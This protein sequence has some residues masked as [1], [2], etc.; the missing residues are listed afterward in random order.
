MKDLGGAKPSAKDAG[1]AKANEPSRSLIQQQPIV[2]DDFNFTGYLGAQE[3]ATAQLRRVTEKYNEILMNRL[4][5]DPV[6]VLQYAAVEFANREAT[7]SR[8]D[9]P[10]EERSELAMEYSQKV[11]ACLQAYRNMTRDPQYDC[12]P[13]IQAFRRQIRLNGGMA[14]L[15][16]AYQSDLKAAYMSILRNVY[17]VLPYQGAPVP[18]IQP[19]MSK[20]NLYR[21]MLVEGQFAVSGPS[22]FDYIMRAACGQAM[23]STPEMSYFPAAPVTMF[24]PDRVAVLAQPVAIYEVPALELDPEITI[25]AV[26]RDMKMTGV[27]FRQFDGEW[28]R[29]TRGLPNSMKLLQWSSFHVC[30]FVPSDYFMR[31]S[32]KCA[33]PDGAVDLSQLCRQSLDPNWQLQNKV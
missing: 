7:A 8:I 18:C 22:M 6:T 4:R 2:Y 20:E 14:R 1:G 33:G 29:K 15:A 19:S 25:D 11:E 5:S 16:T 12:E 27:K 9:L 21:S 24:R 13:T 30:R 28:T 23:F 31:K 10:P 26:W 17:V 3:Q 32:V